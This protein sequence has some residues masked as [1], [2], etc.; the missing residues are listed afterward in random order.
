MNWDVYID[1]FK[2]KLESLDKNK[3]INVTVLP[4][5]GAKGDAQEIRDSANY[6][7][8]R[9]DVIV[10]AGTAA[11]L[12]CIDV[13]K[14]NKKPPVVFASVGDPTRSG[15]DQPQPGRWYT[16]GSNGQVAYVKDRLDYMLKSTPGKPAFN[17]PFAVVGYY[18]N[19]KDDPATAAMEAAYS[20]LSKRVGAANVVLCKI[21][22]TDTMDKFIKDIKNLKPAPKSLYCC[23]D[24]RLTAK[25][26]EL[27]DAADKVSMA[28]MWEFEE[29][30]TKHHGRMLRA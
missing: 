12:I 6:M 13:T 20:E 3:Y 15:L 29:H 26:I 25:A 18:K 16:G 2:K 28:T 1:A 23:S 5:R 30:K 7:L 4:R 10:T 9:V 8:N 24:L 27:N 22:V 11:T 14:A 19:P 21:A 17:P